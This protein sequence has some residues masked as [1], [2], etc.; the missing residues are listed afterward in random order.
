M[1][2]PYQKFPLLPFGKRQDWGDFK[3]R[4]EEEES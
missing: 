3:E 1:A 2:C 4:A